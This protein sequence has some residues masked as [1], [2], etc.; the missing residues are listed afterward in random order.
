METYLRLVLAEA[1]DLLLQVL[2]LLLLLLIDLN[3][4]LQISLTIAL[5]RVHLVDARLQRLLVLLTLGQLDL[6]ISQTLL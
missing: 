5:L 2:N 4:L 6:H 1:I 3:L